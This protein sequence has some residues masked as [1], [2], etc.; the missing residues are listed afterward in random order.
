MTAQLIGEKVLNYHIKAFLH[1]EGYYDYYLAEHVLFKR[2]V[3]V[4]TL[5]PRYLQHIEAQNALKQEA[6]YPYF[7][8]PQSI[9]L[10]DFIETSDNLYL[11]TQCL[12][13]WLTLEQY[14]IQHGA[15]PEEKMLRLFRQLLDILQSAHQVGLYHPTLCPRNILIEGNQIKIIDF[16]GKTLPDPAYQS[17]EQKQKGQLTAQSNIYT[18]GKI[19]AFMLFARPELPKKPS[20]NPKLHEAIAVAI[21]K[22]PKERFKSCN[23]LA[24]A[25]SEEVSIEEVEIKH[26]FTQLPLLILVTLLSLLVVTLYGIINENDYKGTLTYNLYDQA[27]IKRLQ[28]SVKNAKRQEFLRDSLRIAQ[29]K[30]ENLQKIHI[31]KVKPGETLRDIAEKYNMS[32]SH[33]KQLNG[34]KDEI[35]LNTDVGLRV[36]I[37][38]YHKVL[39]KEELWQIAQKYGISK[40]DIIKANNIEDELHDVYPGAN[41]IIPIKK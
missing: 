22:N 13:N 1:S 26:A 8:H 33:L 32:L 2:K 18:L 15:M 9:I 35:Y 38:N 6:S 23:E 4:K 34:L 21:E 31:H 37:R 19:A 27:R 14:I 39:D 25:L 10:Y 7:A 30:A 24:K 40:D 11:I 12:E 5:N 36:V 16:E 41:L 28:D 17:P 20:I 29:N 3:L